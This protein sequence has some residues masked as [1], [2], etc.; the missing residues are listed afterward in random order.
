MLFLFRHA[1]LLDLSGKPLASTPIEGTKEKSSLASGIATVLE[2]RYSTERRLP[3]KAN[4]CPGFET[5]S[6]Q[7]K[8]SP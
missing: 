1:A 4:I 3:V 2:E 8:S 6:A 7:A 5:I